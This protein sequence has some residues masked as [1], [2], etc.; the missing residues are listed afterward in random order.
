LFFAAHRFFIA[1]DSAFRPAAVR[2]PFLTAAAA[3]AGAALG[4]AGTGA[5][6]AAAAAAFA[7]LIAAERFFAPAMIARLPAA[8]IF[9]FAGAV[10]PTLAGGFESCSTDDRTAFRPGPGAF[11]VVVGP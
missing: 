1:I 3:L 6:A 11:S 10:G 4:A 5:G 9:R 7:A 8:L 2:P